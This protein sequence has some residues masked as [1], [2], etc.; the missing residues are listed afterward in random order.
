MLKS[1][2]PASS[3]SGNIEEGIAQFRAVFTGGT[4]KLL[5]DAQA[6]GEAYRGFRIENDGVGEIV[7]FYFEKRAGGG[8]AFT[9]LARKQIGTAASLHDIGLSKKDGL[10]TLWHNRAVLATWPPQESRVLTWKGGAFGLAANGSSRVKL[11]RWSLRA[12]RQEGRSSAG[13]RRRRAAK[14][15][16]ELASLLSFPPFSPAA[17]VGSSAAEWPPVVR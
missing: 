11:F 3:G 2:L 12:N 14:G 5:A 10:L 16:P 1:T 4:L 17:G 9:R 7:A 6:D 8:E 13:L 15:A